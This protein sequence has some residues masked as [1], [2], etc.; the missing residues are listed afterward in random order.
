MYPVLYPEMLV[1]INRTSMDMSGHQIQITIANKGIVR[2]SGKASEGI[3]HAGG[4]GRGIRTPD[5]REAIT[6]FKSAG[7]NHSPI[8]P[9]GRSFWIGFRQGLKP[10]RCSHVLDARFAGRHGW[11]F[12]TSFPDR[13]VF[14]HLLWHP[15]R[16]EGGYQAS[17]PL[18]F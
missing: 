17:W 18:P 15:L 8:P 4:G 5:D 7:F 13:S 10:F 1:G 6:D 16:V 9:E 3:E 2:I 11:F 12:L 14:R